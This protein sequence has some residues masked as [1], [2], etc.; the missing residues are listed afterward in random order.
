MTPEKPIRHALFLRLGNCEL[1]ALGLPA[2]TAV[3]VV[4]LA[5][6]GGRWLGL[7]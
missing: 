7:L 4:V 2:I 6:L 3:V 1:R 5:L